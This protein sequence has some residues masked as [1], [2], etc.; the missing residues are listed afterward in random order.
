MLRSAIRNL[1]RP[2]DDEPIQ[3]HINWYINQGYRVMSQTD[4]SAQLVKPKVFSFMWAL[5]WL[6]VGLGIGLVLYLIYYASKKD[7]TVYL[8]VVDG[9]V[10]TS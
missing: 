1:S 8:S 6:I 3:T 5:I 10:R 4:A 7:K 2:K 9:K